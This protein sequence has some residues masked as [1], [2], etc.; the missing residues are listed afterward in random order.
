MKH[1]L[2]L[3]TSQTQHICSSSLLDNVQLNN[4]D[5][6]SQYE[7]YSYLGVLLNKEEKDTKEIQNRIRTKSI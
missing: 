1:D 2:V 6:I 7:K 3:N 4:G 5:E